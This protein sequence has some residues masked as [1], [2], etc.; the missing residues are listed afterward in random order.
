MEK[1]VRYRI[2][3]QH[4]DTGVITSKDFNYSAIFSGAAIKCIKTQYKR[5]SII[6]KSEFTGRLDC[7]G[8]RIYEND[9]IEFDAKEWGNDFSN[10]HK[11]TWDNKNSEW[12]WGGGIASDMEFRRVI[13]NKFDNAK[14]W[15]NL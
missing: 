5:Y 7:N 10:I 12:C 3:L 8:N 14:L 2:H 15:E 1:E 13:G 6:G 9:I 4:E 11:V